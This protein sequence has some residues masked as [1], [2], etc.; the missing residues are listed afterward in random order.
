MNRNYNEIS[1]ATQDAKQS[2]AQD[3]RKNINQVANKQINN[4]NMDANST[5][6]YY[7]GNNPFCNNDNDRSY[8][9]A[10][11]GTFFTNKIDT[12]CYMVNSKDTRISTIDP[13]LTAM[14]INIS[15]NGTPV[16]AIFDT[17][18]PVT[19]VKEKVW[20]NFVK[21]TTLEPIAVK[22]FSCKSEPLN[23]L[24][25]CV[26]DVSHVSFRGQVAISLYISDSEYPIE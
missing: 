5:M 8:E 1:T 10:T 4:V 3:A 24:G 18:S 15:M 25:S 19:I 7:S 17:G 22:I 26:C 23:V 2:L 6:Q 11:S 12:S 14:T 16:K 21:R 9:T 20:R 13:N